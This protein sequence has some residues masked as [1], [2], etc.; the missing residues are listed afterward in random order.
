MILGAGVMQAPLIKKAR[1][2]G[3]FALVVGSKGNFPGLQYA[4]KAIFQDFCDSEA[5]VQIAHEEKIDG[6]WTCGLDLPVRTMSIVSEKLGLPGISAEA[7]RI[8][9]DKKKMKECFLAGGVRTAKFEIATSR[10]SGYE[11]FER[12][13]SAVMFKA[14][15]S[16]GSTGI[17]KVTSKEQIPYA[18]KTVKNASRSEH[19]VIEEFLD[20]E[21]FGAQA[22]VVDGKLKFVLPHG[23]YVFQG[24]TGVPIGHFVPCSLSQKNIDDCS[25]ELEKCIKAIGL[26]T[27]AINADFML[28]NDQVYFLE[29]GAR[30]GA[31]MLAET[32]S[33]FFGI[34][35]YEQMINAALGKP[36]RF[37]AK[38]QGSPNITMTLY[39]DKN[40][41]ITEQQNN[42][43][44]NEDIVEVHFDYKT[45]DEVRKFKL[46]KDRI[47]HVIVK[48]KS[49]ELAKK[50]L[51]DC[52]QNVILK[53]KQF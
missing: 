50:T 21:E 46:G 43:P 39:S 23:D 28:C 53:V 2:L 42:N 48:G 29:I 5:V 24:D 4:S 31:T 25:A 20:G 52:M 49:L 16:Q 37:P 40:G 13:G 3:Y 8:V 33:L 1:E 10:E 30:C 44:T 6:V 47:G 36:V 12:F 34:D 41:I 27:C 18:Y 26:K 51:H 14:P 7:G 17:V 22:L 35:Y 45:G 11:I 38:P 15:D 32:T 9:N 19:Y